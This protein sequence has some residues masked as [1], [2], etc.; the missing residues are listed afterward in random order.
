MKKSVFLLAAVCAAACLTGCGT[1]S[2]RARDDRYE[3]LNEMLRAEYS[4]IVLTVTDTFDG[5]T[6]L[7]SEYV[8]SYSDGGVTVEYTAER[9]A[10]I[11]DLGEP[12]PEAKTTLSGRAVVKDGVIVSAEGDDVGLSADIAKTGF[13]F[14]EEYFENAEFGDVFFAADVKDADAFFGTRISGSGMK[15][16]A[17][18]F[19][20]FSELSVTYLSAG[21]YDVEFRYVFSL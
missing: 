13:T 15:A 11:G 4:R 14:K 1:E 8:L 20:V 5:G 7:K 17:T 10:V 18:F 9:F 16:E 6:F 21:G 3:H 2:E 19:D 12:L